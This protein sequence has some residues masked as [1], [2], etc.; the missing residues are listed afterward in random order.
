MMHQFP[1]LTT[2][3]ASGISKT[4]LVLDFIVE[5]A[6][7]SYNLPQLYLESEHVCVCVDVC[8]CVRWQRQ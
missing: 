6:K 4:F 3:P 7:L 2:Q 5:A 1:A 8:M